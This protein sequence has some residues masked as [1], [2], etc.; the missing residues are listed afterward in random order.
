MNPLEIADWRFLISEIEGTH[1]FEM[2]Q[3]PI[4]DLQ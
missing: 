4:S 3:F 2:Q 1:K